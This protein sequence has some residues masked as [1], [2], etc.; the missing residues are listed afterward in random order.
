MKFFLEKK[1]FFFFYKLKL[2]K[3]SIFLCSRNILA[4]S[5]NLTIL[6][7]PINLCSKIKFKKKIKIDLFYV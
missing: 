3:N 7:N 2:N 6:F 4:F 5:E 1:N